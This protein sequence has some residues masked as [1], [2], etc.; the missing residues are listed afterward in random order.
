MSEKKLI[1]YGV[2]NWEK[3]VDGHYVVDHTRF[4]PEL[5]KCQTPVFLRPKRFG[6]SVVCSMLEHYYDINR[7][8]DFERLFG[9]SDIG[10]NPT[11]LRNSFLVIQFDFSKVEPASTIDEIERLF[12][13]YVTGIV[14]VFAAY[15]AVVDGRSI[16]WS[17]AT[18]ADKAAEAVSALCNVIAENKLPPLYVIVDEYDNFT[19]ELVVANREH[20][21]DAICGHDN[22]GLRRDSFFKS[23]F[24]VFKAGLKEGTVGRTYFT[25]VLPI[26]LDDLSSGFNVGTVVSLNRKLLN[27]VGFTKAELFDYVD[28]IF[29]DYG[30]DPAKKEKVLS[31]IKAFYDGYRMLPDGDHLYNATITNWYL[32]KLVMDE[33]IIP[34][35]VIDSN[36]RTD[37]GWFR[38][39]AGAKARDRVR[40]YIERGEGEIVQVNNLSSRFGRSKFFSDEF[41]PYAL[42]Y[43]GLMTF[44]GNFRLEIPNL[45]IKS[46]F[47]DYYDE[48]SEV[49]NVD[50]ARRA[51][52]TAAEDLAFNGGTWENLFEQYWI[53]YVKARIPAQ[54]F[55]KINENFF[56]LTF[57]SRAFDALL[58]YYSFEQEYNTPEGRVDFLATPRPGNTRPALLIEFKYFKSSELAAIGVET[59]LDGT[60]DVSKRVEPDA[61]TLAQARRYRDSLPKRPGWDAAIITKVIEVY[62]HYGYKWFAVD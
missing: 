36:V 53:H 38:K 24:K 2:M 45:T 27:L 31:D 9:W 4:I 30:F 42:Y 58:G 10:K 32:F 13:V 59:R 8:D 43:L 33:G 57:T 5:E 34:T 11:K 54:A 47:I 55:D 15:Y 41:F 6:K 26:T 23:F 48:L 1:P 25:G 52:L 16:D 50:E 46:L 62:C 21:Y 28:R 37:I 14:R 49:T 20:D 35:D 29:A 39:L 17:Q 56:R 44:K 61:E 3:L 60:C 12:H 19:N 18:D 22:T 51:F 7:K 40:G